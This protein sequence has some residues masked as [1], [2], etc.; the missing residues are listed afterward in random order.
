MVVVALAAMPFTQ[1]SPEE[2]LVKIFVLG[3]ESKNSCLRISKGSVKRPTCEVMHDLFLVMVTREL[4]RERHYRRVTVLIPW[5][6]AAMALAYLDKELKTL[7][8]KFPPSPSK[9]DGAG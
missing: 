7:V 9:Y 3:L 2:R 1:P 8:L 6:D 5:S 4:L